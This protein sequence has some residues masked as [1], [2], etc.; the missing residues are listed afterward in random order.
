MEYKILMNCKGV[1]SIIFVLFNLYFII[2]SYGSTKKEYENM[3][4]K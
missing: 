4:K 1:Y 3:V 2:I